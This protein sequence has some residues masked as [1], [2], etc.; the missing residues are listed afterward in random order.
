MRRP[1]PETPWDKL[2]EIRANCLVPK[3]PPGA[4]TAAEYSKKY[5]INRRTA[6]DQLAALVRGGK[7]TKHSQEGHRDYNYYL[8]VSKAPSK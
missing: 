7:L 1:A 6:Y 3:L 2:D 8:V 4:F 5:G